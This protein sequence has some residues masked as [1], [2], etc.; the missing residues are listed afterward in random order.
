MTTTVWNVLN[1]HAQTPSDLSEID[2]DWARVQVEAHLDEYPQVRAEC[3]ATTPEEWA[4]IA[5]DFKD[6][7][8][9]AMCDCMQWER[10]NGY[11][12]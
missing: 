6:N 5:S 11:D 1:W 9:T 7:M 10:D 8:H 3:E 12:Y 2:A 4:G